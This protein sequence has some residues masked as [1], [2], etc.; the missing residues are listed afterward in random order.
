MPRYHSARRSY[1]L[2][3]VLNDGVQDEQ[4]Y[5]RQT[6]ENRDQSAC[7]IAFQISAD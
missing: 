6:A 4:L 1:S 2:L 7:N 3:E 5:S